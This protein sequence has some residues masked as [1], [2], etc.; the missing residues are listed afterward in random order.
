MAVMRRFHQPLTTW[1]FA[2]TRGDPDL[3]PL[4]ADFGQGVAKLRFPDGEW[5]GLFR[6]V[7]KV[8]CLDADHAV[9]NVYSVGHLHPALV[10]NDLRTLVLEETRR[11][12]RVAR[13]VVSR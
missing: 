8:F 12:S 3:E 5:S 1:H 9:R 7:L 2:T 6:H 11:R 13:R 4:L 10:L